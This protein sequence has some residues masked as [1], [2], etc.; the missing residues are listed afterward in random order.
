MRDSDLLHIYV[1]QQSKP[2]GIN[3]LSHESLDLVI[4]VNVTSRQEA[5]DCWPNFKL[6]LF[7]DGASIACFSKHVT[8]YMLVD[9]FNEVKIQSFHLLAST[10]LSISRIQYT[11]TARFWKKHGKSRKS[12]TLLVLS[13]FHKK[14]LPY[15][16]NLPERKTVYGTR[17]VTSSPFRWYMHVSV[18]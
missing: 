1:T 5:D 15:I 10:T 4:T 14:N 11:N 8:S 3:N 13:F 16:T 17:F 18:H 2:I 12:E 9:Y 7:R 6:R